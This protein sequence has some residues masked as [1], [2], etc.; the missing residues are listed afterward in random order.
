MTEAQKQFIAKYTPV[1]IESTKGTNIFPSVKMAQLILE[2]GWGKSIKK[3]GNNMFGIKAGSK[4]NGPVISNS[5]REVLSGIDQKF[6]GTGKIYDS[7]KDAISAG[8]EPQTL[9]RYYKTESDSLRDHSTLLLTKSR[10]LPVINAKTPVEQAQALQTSG[11][12][13]DPNYAAALIRI[14]NNYNLSEIDK[15]K[16][17]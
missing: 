6:S 3:A 8:V 14:I 17:L 12:A 16:D 4:W 2:T 13:T 9:F 7:Y 5:T 15:K 11:Y 1:V 10:Y